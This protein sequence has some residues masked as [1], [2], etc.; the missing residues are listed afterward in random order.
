MRKNK[1]G[2]YVE[3]QQNIY[4]IIQVGYIYQL[5]KVKPKNGLRLTSILSST[6]THSLKVMNG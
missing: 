5:W 1:H 4:V 6:I 2:N 3:H